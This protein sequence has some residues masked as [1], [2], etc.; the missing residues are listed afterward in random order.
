MRLS[1]SPEFALFSFSRISFHRQMNLIVVASRVVRSDCRI[2]SKLTAVAISERWSRHYRQRLLSQHETCFVEGAPA[3]SS[4]VKV[5]LPLA[6][7]WQN[8]FPGSWGAL[9][10]CPPPGHQHSRNTASTVLRI[11]FFTARLANSDERIRPKYLRRRPDDELHGG[12]GD[13]SFSRS[14]QAERS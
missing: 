4:S 13:L 5:R 3:C 1:S 12:D 2:A 9:P 8:L 6:R 7:A 14:A 10:M 11:N